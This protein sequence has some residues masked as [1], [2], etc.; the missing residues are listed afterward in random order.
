MSEEQPVFPPDKEKLFA[1]QFEEDYD[2]QDEEY[3]AWVRIN[4]PG[5]CLSVSSS[6]SSSSSSSTSGPSCVRNV[7]N[8]TSPPQSTQDQSSESD[9]LSEILVLPKP[10]EKSGRKRKAAVNQKA[11]CLTDD[12]VLDHLKADDEKKKEDTLRK[13]EK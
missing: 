13:L 2:I 6:S 11:V 5:R 3:I 9:M 1:Q 12:S 8:S 4:H 10:R 7:V